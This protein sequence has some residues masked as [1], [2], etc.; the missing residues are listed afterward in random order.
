MK[1]AM[2]TYAFARY[3]TVVIGLL[4][5]AILSRILLPE[6]YG[7]IAVVT[8]FTAL[9]NVLSTMG[10][11]TGLIQ[12]KELTEEDTD[13]IYSLSVWIALLLGVVFFVCAWPIASF[14]GDDRYIVIVQVLSIS[15]FLNAIN[16]IPN[17]I[18]L[19]EEQFKKIA[20][21]MIMASCLSGAVAIIMALNNGGYYALV[22]QTILS[23]AI[24]FIWNRASVKLHFH[25]KVNMVSVKKIANYS[26][27]QFAYSLLLYLSQNLDNLLTGKVMGSEQLAYYNKSYSVMRYPIDYIPHAISPV[28]HPVLSK[29]QDDSEYIY[30]K[31]VD[32]I[33]VMSL[34]GVFVSLIFF[35]E[36]P[37]IIEL[38]FG[39]QWGQSIPSFRIFGIGIW[40]QLVNALAGS[41]YQSTNNTK[42]MF[43][44]GLIHVVITL[45][46]IIA[47][48]CSNDINILAIYI[49]ISWYIKFLVETYFLVFK[50]L[51][52]NV[53]QYLKIFLPDLVIFVVTGVIYGFVQQWIHFGILVNIVVKSLAIGL[54]F[55]VCCICFGQVKYIK[56]LVGK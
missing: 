28:L 50:S 15:V 12:N 16:V 14:Y 45:V 34:I 37:E 25:L 6:D 19:K 9:F 20:F 43:Y 31:Y 27:F 47:G 48:I 32:I 49:V 54:I 4:I 55:V 13:N 8:V 44:S 36:A 29:Y 22:V 18:L 41:I 24:Q 11:G 7:I 30:K 3:S 39:K 33:K 21:R 56:K 23:I 1:K 38:L 35:W 10:L 40:V 5:N 46:A 42:N 17:A 26:F 51:K 2:F 53:F 52:K